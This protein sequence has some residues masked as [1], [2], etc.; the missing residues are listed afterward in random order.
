MGAKVRL[1]LQSESAKSAEPTEEKM[2]SGKAQRTQ[3]MG[4]FNGFARPRCAQRAEKY[5]ANATL[6]TGI[7]IVFDQRKIG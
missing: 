6:I 3:K 5:R 1:I 2:E 4:I 7:W